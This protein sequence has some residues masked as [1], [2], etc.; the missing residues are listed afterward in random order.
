MRA[1]SMAA[2]FSF[3]RVHR[4]ADAEEFYKQTLAAEETKLGASH[5]LVALTFQDLGALQAEEERYSEAESSYRRVRE[6]TPKPCRF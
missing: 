3:Y 6:S 5:P 4:P 2:A 1:A